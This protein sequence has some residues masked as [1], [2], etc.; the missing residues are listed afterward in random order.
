M[1][2]AISIVNPLQALNRRPSS[3]QF[4]SADL[5]TPDF[6]LTSFCIPI[7]D[8]PAT[9]SATVAAWDGSPYHLEARSANRADSERNCR[10]GLDQ[11]RSSEGRQGS[12]T[13]WS[14]WSSGGT[15]MKW[16]CVDTGSLRRVAAAFDELGAV[17]SG[18]VVVPS[19]RDGSVVSS[20][21]CCCSHVVSLCIR[22]ELG[23]EKLHFGDRKTTLLQLG[24]SGSCKMDVA[25]TKRVQ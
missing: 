13:R 5:R 1:D 21:S 25:P 18:L 19:S 9:T 15:A 10:G 2:T 12:T 20:S 17:S 11:G 24:M 22:D 14:S 7:F 8:Q 3:F 6:H 16:C 23:R 4:P